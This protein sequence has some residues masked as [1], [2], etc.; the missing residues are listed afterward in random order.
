MHYR[1]ARTR[2][3]GSPSRQVPE[4]VVE[5]RLHA[6]AI[7]DARA[8][9]IETPLRITPTALQPDRPATRRRLAPMWIVP[10][11]AALAVS[12][13]VLTVGGYALLAPATA[14]ASLALTP[15]WV[16][17]AGSATQSGESRGAIYAIAAHPGVRASIDGGALVDLPLHVRDIE[18]GHHVVRFEAGE[19]YETD[20][21]AVRVTAG[22]ISDLGLIA[23][24]LR[25]AKLHV[26]AEVGADVW[27]RGSRGPARRLKGPWPR[28]LELEPGDYELI[29]ARYGYR[30]IVRPL[31]FD[32]AR[33]SYRVNLQLTPTA[34]KK[35]DV[36]TLDQS[37]DVEM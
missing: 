27:L 14:E 25:V 29:A 26:A 15:G 33:P 31:H 37:D 24:R 11:L 9:R 28:V 22:A 17:A 13:L 23:L 16:A 34:W 12:L 21:R 1:F 7:I 10:A 30:S 5:A 4:E 19:Q 2:L 18:P 35:H 20:L 8:A 36:W 6:R 3:F 32:A